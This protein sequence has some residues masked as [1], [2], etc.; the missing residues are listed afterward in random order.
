MRI[1]VS[2]VIFSVMLT[3]SESG[4]ILPLTSPAMAQTSQCYQ[5]KD[6][7]RQRVC[8]SGE[9]DARRYA[10]DA[11]MWRDE[12]ARIRRDYETACQRVG[13]IAKFAGQGRT[14]KAA[15]VAPGLI[16]DRINR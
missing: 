13:K 14:F 5:I 6:V 4:L 15:C 16:N 12:E 1:I 2:S 11:Q 9:S 3:A 10:Q 8:L 7:S